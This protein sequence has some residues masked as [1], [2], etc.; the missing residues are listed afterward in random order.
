MASVQ[1]A[2]ETKDL[3]FE[4]MVDNGPHPVIK[5]EEQES[6]GPIPREEGTERPGKGLHIV[7]GWGSWVGATLSRVGTCG[8][9]PSRTKQEDVKQEV[10]WEAEWQEF[11]KALQSPHTDWVRPTLLEAAGEGGSGSEVSGWL[12]GQVE[13]RLPL[14]LEGGGLQA[15]RSPEA[16][17][18]GEVKGEILGEEAV[19]AEAQRQHFRQFRYLEGKGPR[20]VCSRLWYLCHR[21]LKPERHTKEQIVELVTLEQFVA[22]LPSEIQGWV[23]EAGVET[24]TQAVA[25]A[26]DFLQRQQEAGKRELQVPGALMEV[27]ASFPEADRAVLNARERNARGEIKLESDR[28]AS[29]L[30]ASWESENNTEARVVLKTAGDME[31]TIGKHEGPKKQQRNNAEKWKEKS[32]VCPGT[33]VLEFKAKQRL[34]EGKRRHT[35]SECGKSFTCKSS[36]TRHQITHTGENPHKCSNCGEKFTRRASLIVHQRIHTGE[37]PYQCFTCGK[38]FS[39]NSTLIRHQRIHTGEKPYQCFDCGESFN[40]RT[41]LISHQRIHTGEKPYQCLDCGESFRDKSSHI[42]HQRIHT[43]EKPYKCSDCGMS[44]REKSSRIRHQRIHTGEKPYKCLDCGESFSQSSTLIRHRKI[45]IGEIP[46]LCSERK[47]SFCDKSNVKKQQNGH[48][49]EEPDKY[50]DCGESFSQDTSQ[51][52][53][54]SVHS[55]DK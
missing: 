20:E 21:W 55:G 12:K 6:T 18:C 40:Q 37:K 17:A 13:T 28:D 23:R 44:F 33:K 30:G 9:F 53:Q 4:V 10:A 5:M 45:H 3:H 8:E 25:L 51:L 7:P 35:C 19:R 52:W 1:G 27:A 22:V 16:G 41:I 47:E 46:H 11:L 42:R 50:A 26:E 38:S 49:Q 39:V 54:Q 48:L 36:L 34:R 24:C 15:P 43:G 31:E 2:A 14:S 32:T 29:L